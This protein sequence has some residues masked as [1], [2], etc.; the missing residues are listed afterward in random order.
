M[1]VVRSIMATRLMCVLACL[2]LKD[3]TYIIMGRS[4]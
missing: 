4:V 3:Y 2:I 1:R